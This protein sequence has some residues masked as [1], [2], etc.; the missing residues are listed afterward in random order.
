MAA[1]RAGGV[2]VSMAIHDFGPDEKGVRSSVFGNMDLHQISNPA[3][4]RAGDIQYTTPRTLNPE[5]RNPGT[6]Y[7]EG[8]RSS[9]FAIW[10]YFTIPFRPNSAI[11][12]AYD[13]IASF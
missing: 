11:L 2:L 12:S 6:G 1:W 7:I 8:V 10:I 13:G 5:L 3:P 9:G 4:P